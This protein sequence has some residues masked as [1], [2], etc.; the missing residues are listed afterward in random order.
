L[1]CAELVREVGGDAKMRE[2][3][4]ENAEMAYT[5]ALRLVAKLLMTEDEVREITDDLQRLRDLLA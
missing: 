1:A 5:T 3:H 4:R 2:Q